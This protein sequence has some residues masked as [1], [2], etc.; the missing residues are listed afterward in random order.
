MIADDVPK[1]VIHYLDVEKKP[2]IYFYRIPCWKMKTVVIEEKTCSSG[3]VDM[4]IRV[5]TENG[6]GRRDLRISFTVFSSKR[7]KG[8]KIWAKKV[9]QNVSFDLEVFFLDKF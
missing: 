3:Q 1:S 4:V 2:S 9:Q 6:L 8:K 5:I 7:K